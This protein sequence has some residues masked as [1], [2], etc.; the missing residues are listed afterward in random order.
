M[1]IEVLGSP[2]GVVR[3]SFVPINLVEL[4]LFA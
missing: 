4:K 1:L 3:K 2:P